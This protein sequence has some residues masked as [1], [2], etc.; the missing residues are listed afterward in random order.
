MGVR[1]GVCVIV[2]QIMQPHLDCVCP[3]PSFP[4]SPHPNG[5]RDCLPISLHCLDLNNSR[6]DQ[7]PLLGNTG[8]VP[9][10]FLSPQDISLN[11][12]T[13]STPEI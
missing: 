12:E 11:I 10:H 2:A 6:K 4:A 1:E 8:P 9:I 5:S 7:I 3:E 13:V